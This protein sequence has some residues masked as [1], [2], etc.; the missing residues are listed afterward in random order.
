MKKNTSDGSAILESK[1]TISEM[2]EVISTWHLMTDWN[3]VVILEI[4]CRDSHGNHSS[5]FDALPSRIRIRFFPEGG[6][7]W[8]INEK[9]MTG[10]PML[11]NE[12]LR[13]VAPG[14]YGRK[15][16]AIVRKVRKA[17]RDLHAK[18]KPRKKKA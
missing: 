18:P 8:H 1:G 6:E 5:E 9:L 3:K 15:A 10:V 16:M 7:E 14:E 12:P 4:P 17:A 11:T 13:T 2:V